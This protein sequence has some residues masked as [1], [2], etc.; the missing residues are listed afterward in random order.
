[1]NYE[2][3]VGELR[4]WNNLFGG[5]VPTKEE[6]EAAMRGEVDDEVMSLMRSYCHTLDRDT[7]T[8]NAS[9]IYRKTWTLAEFEA[10]VAYFIA[11][12]PEDKRSTACVELKGGY[13]ETSELVVTYERQQT[14]E[15]WATDV[16]RALMYARKKQADDLA[17]YRRMKN[18][19]DTR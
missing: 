12:V 9:Y 16:A 18:K 10:E 17:V 5:G 6:I 11:S 13:E 2:S 3:I 4:R 14:D 1:M 15:E 7:V 19:Y 8:H